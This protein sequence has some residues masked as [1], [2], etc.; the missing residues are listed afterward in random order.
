MYTQLC[1]LE[2]KKTTKLQKGKVP[3]NFYTN[4]NRKG[5]DQQLDQTHKNK[6]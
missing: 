6:E 5:N 3:G 4:M 2:I 1:K